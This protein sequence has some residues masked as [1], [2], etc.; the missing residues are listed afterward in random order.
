[1][2]NAVNRQ[3]PGQRP[4]RYDSSRRRAAAEET[5]TRILEAARRLFIADGYAV[6]TV[7]AIARQADVVP[8]TVYA[9]VGRKAALFRALIELALSGTGQPVPG[10]QRDYAER[11]RAASDPHRKLAIYAEAVTAIQARLAP[12]FLV[13]R[14]ASAVDAEL[15]ALWDEITRRRSDN[16]RALAADLASTGAT[17]ADLTVDEMADVIWTM[18]SSEYYSL[19]VIDRGWSERRFCEWLLDSWSRLLLDQKAAGKSA[20]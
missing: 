11:V 10:A 15:K 7:A 4:R 6:T 16:M 8:D 20:D 5:R 12:L 14:E 2:S 3:P 19:L 18:N 9:T 1:M 13:L 17:R